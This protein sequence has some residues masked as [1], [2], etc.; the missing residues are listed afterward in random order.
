[1]VVVVVWRGGACEGVG[2]VGAI[3]LAPASAPCWQTTN[4]LLLKDA[5]EYFKF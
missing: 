3:T 2:C 1:M 4:R 5:Q